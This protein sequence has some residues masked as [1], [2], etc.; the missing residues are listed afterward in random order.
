MQSAVRAGKQYAI[1]GGLGLLLMALPASRA[2]SSGNLPHPDH[3]EKE[4]HRTIAA[5]EEQWRAATLSNDVAAIDRMLADDY[6]GIGP[7]GTIASKADEMAA[8]RDGQR[9]L[10]Q[11]DVLE[12]K[13]R[14][15]GTTAVV[16]SRA[17]VTGV[18]DTMPLT[19]EFRYTRV[20]NLSHGQWRIVSF[21]ASPITGTH[22]H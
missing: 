16:T 19:G 1:L 17:I 21:E 4:V 11:I 5:L 13:V 12:R 3:G 2:L 15:Y 20:Y 10:T 18:Y 8:R 6:V 9:K 14:I 7:D 22:A